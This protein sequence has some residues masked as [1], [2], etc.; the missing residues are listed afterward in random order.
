MTTAR[1]WP[2]AVVMG[3]ADFFLGG[4]FMTTRPVTFAALLLLALCVLPACRSTTSGPLPE[5]LMFE[6][7]ESGEDAA[8]P[9]ATLQLIHSQ[10]ELDALRSENLRSL[11]V[12]FARQSLILLALGE[13]PTGGYWARIESAYIQNGILYVQG[14]ANAPGPDQMVTQTITYPYAVAILAKAQAREVVGDIT[15]VYGQPH[16]GLKN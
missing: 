9:L 13:Q 16:P 7:R 4:S 6:I 3:Y 2:L 10:R 1:H 8:L 15:S 12:D 5:V 14:T 11:P